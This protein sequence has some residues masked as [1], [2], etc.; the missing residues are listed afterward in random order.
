MRAPGCRAAQSAAEG[1]DRAISQDQPVPA[2]LRCSRYPDDRSATCEGRRAA[3][4]DEACPPERKDSTVAR[5]D[6]IATAICCGCNGNQGGGQVG[7]P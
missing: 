1:D 5:G 3:T 7:R 6:E 2:A 4:A